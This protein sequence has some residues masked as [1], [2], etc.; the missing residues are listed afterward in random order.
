MKYENYKALKEKVDKIGR[1]HE[2]YESLLKSIAKK[3]GRDYEDDDFQEET[4][5]LLW[6]KEQVEYLMLAEMIEKNNLVYD[7][8]TISFIRSTRQAVDQ[9]DANIDESFDLICD[10]I[11]PKV[12]EY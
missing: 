5:D 12:A 3:E 6:K 1:C 10:I 8:L 4:N 11:A 7:D 9:G 2:E